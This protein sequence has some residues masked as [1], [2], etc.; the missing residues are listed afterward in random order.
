MA[1]ELR[2]RLLYGRVAVVGVIRRVGSK[3][4]FGKAAHMAIELS[5]GERF[6]PQSVGRRHRHDVGQVVAHPVRVPQDGRID[7]RKRSDQVTVRRRDG[8]PRKGFERRTYRVLGGYAV[9]APGAISPRFAASG[10]LR[11]AVDEE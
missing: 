9:R 1:R 2:D 3:V 5:R 7:D 11:L 6:E 4:Q 8:P 10:A